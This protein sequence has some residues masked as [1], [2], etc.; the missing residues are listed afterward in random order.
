M[1]G[2]SYPGSRPAARH[3]KDADN[4]RQTLG[5]EARAGRVSRQASGETGDA[6]TSVDTA[7]VAPPLAETCEETDD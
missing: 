6:E 5:G 4:G 7:R 3:G 2:G 1:C